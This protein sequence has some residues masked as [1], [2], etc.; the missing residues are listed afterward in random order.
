MTYEGKDT[1][2]TIET[3]KDGNETLQL[4]LQDVQVRVFLVALP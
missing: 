3:L 4:Q 1:V 2:I